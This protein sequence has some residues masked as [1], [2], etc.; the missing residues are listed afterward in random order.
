MSY[1]YSQII[2]IESIIEELHDM[3]LSEQERMHLA[4]LV[5]S[6]IHHAIIDEVL[7]QLNDEDKKLFLK[8]LA[9]EKS[10]EKISEFLDSKIDNIK[11]KI[12]KVADDLVT[13]MHKDVKEA[14]R[15]K[16]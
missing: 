10:H 6:S 3:D 14:K 11:D 9:E 8:L 15:I 4:A 5:D 7:S 1:F 13:E 16:K 2:S 12:K